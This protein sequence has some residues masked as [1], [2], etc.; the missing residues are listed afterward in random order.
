MSRRSFLKRS[1]MQLSKP[2]SVDLTLAA[3][4]RSGAGHLRLTE[5]D[6]LVIGRGPVL[7]HAS[8]QH[9]QSR[10]W[11]SVSGGGWVSS[12]AVGRGERARSVTRGA[13]L[14]LDECSR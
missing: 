7:S 2:L 14:K 5:I 3:P 13:S 11:S 4:T 1:G 9:F 8:R 6:L 12:L 10:H